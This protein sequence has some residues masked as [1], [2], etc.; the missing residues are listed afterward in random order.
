MPLDVAAVLAARCI[1]ATLGVDVEHWNTEGRQGACDLRYVTDGRTVAVE[2]KRVVDP[3]HRAAEREAD[4]AGY[5]MDDRLSY[6]W[7]VRLR[8]SASWK[9][10]R[11]AMPALLIQLEE[12]GFSPQASPRL[13][14][15]APD[16]QHHLDALGVTG[17]HPNMPTEMHPPG[18]YLMPEG[19]GGGVPDIEAMPRFAVDV[20][21]SAR[22]RTL[23]RQLAAADADERHAFLFVGWEHM[24]ALTLSSDDDALPGEAPNLPLPIDGVWMASTLANSRLIAWLPN[25]GWINGVFADG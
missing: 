21:A 24:A 25:R 10:V 17:T 16:L 14:R 13:R 3:T 18:F 20:L 2:V 4:V 11:Q 15:Y 7:D 12:L 23:R 6:T 9:V 8:T 1:E 22:M 5:T 19:W